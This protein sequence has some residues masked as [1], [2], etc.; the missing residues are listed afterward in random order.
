M[1]IV[2]CNNHVK[3]ATKYF[4]PSCAVNCL[5]DK[6]N[7][8]GDNSDKLCKLC[9]GKIPGGRCTDSDPYAGYDGAFRCLLESGE[10]A[11]LKHNSVQEHI[12][13]MDYGEYL[14]FVWVFSIIIVYFDFQLL[15]P[16]TPSN[17]CAKMAV[18]DQ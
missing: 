15:F 10:I 11:F 5:S 6:Y 12:S 3:S 13:G 9:I 2:D 17:C 7:P 16:K 18:A 8:I 14:N 4:G 1:D